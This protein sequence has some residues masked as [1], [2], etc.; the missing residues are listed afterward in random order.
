MLQT[1]C[2]AV[3]TL[4]FIIV[5][6]FCMGNP[7][8]VL[9][10]TIGYMSPFTEIVYRSTGSPVAGIFL[11]GVST[12]TAIVAVGDLLGASARIIWSLGRDGALPPRWGH[13]SERW[14]VP[15]PA[16]L[17]QFPV[18][19]LITMIY[20]WNSTAF[21]G[22]MGGTLVCFQISYC[23]PTAIKVLNYKH[24]KTLP[25]G[26]WRMGWY[27]RIVDAVSMCFGLF[28]IVFMSF[29]SIVPVTATNMSV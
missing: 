5:V 15:I 10:S 28:M 12:W 21:Y 9:Q 19:V 26:P 6:L 4:P 25:R 17:V 11:N 1:L 14:G 27:G 24:F 20:I 7:D 16:L 2:N 29:P 18:A 3:A 13:L 23:M 8:D 22:L